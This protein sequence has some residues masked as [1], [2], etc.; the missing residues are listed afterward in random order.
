MHPGCVGRFC[1]AARRR[2]G[3]WQALGMAATRAAGYAGHL[4]AFQGT[5][6]PLY[7]ARLC[8]RVLGAA[9]RITR[10]R[11]EREGSS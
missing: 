11:R 1:D 7:A 10:R 4:A 9:L 8:Q 6:L 2:P 3:R 5:R